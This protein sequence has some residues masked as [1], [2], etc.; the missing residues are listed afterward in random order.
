[1]ADTAQLSE[2]WPHCG[3]GTDADSPM[4]CPGRTVEPYAQCLAHLDD[5]DRHAYLASLQP[6]ATVD[7]RGT[8]F[9]A[10]L[11]AELCE[12]LRGPN[13]VAFG[14]GARLWQTQFGEGADFRGVRFGDVTEFSGAT[15]G[16]R[17]DFRGVRFGNWTSFQAVTFGEHVWFN[18]AAFGDDILFQGAKFGRI[19][20]F[21][22]VVFGEGAWFSGATFGHTAEFHMARFDG[23]AGFIGT[24]FGGVATSF[25]AVTFGGE[26]DFR[27]A[28]F[29][30][31]APFR[32]AKFNGAVN[33]GPLRCRNM[34]LS[35]AVFSA[36][37][38]VEA[39]ARKV[40]CADTR[41]MS[42]STMRLRYA[43]V[44]LSG[45]VVESPLTL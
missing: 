12:A 40:V 31:D 44:D 6:G 19:A 13:G 10:D 42:T 37:V 17:A 27:G 34:D 45:A 8:S 33:L 15:F 20:V 38:R 28:T 43:D 25:A 14:D 26:T 1:M 18:E 2:E 11:F 23:N 7:H 30:E 35:R 4:G 5:D 21:S 16:N 9:T 36:P 41:W 32:G 22:E 39:T 29:V 24:V 3:V